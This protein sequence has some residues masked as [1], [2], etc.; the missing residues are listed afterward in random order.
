VSPETKD[1][2]TVAIALGLMAL[3]GVALIF[4][5]PGCPEQDTDYHF[6][7]ARTAWSTPSLFVNVL[8]RPLYTAFYALRALMGFTEARFFAVGIG[9]ALAWQTWRLACDLRLERAWLVVPLLLGQPVFFELFSDLLRS[10]LR[11]CRVAKFTFWRSTCYL[12]TVFPCFAFV[13]AFNVEVALE[14]FLAVFG[15]ASRC[16]PKLCFNDDLLVFLSESSEI[17]CRLRPTRPRLRK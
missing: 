10:G 8:G 2:R 4:L 6:L 15:F 11:V 17:L 16:A 5:F 3:L 12:L 9:V 1:L 7:E 13:P 14:M